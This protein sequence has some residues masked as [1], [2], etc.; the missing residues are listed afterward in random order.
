MC[1]VSGR[2][3]STGSPS[4]TC[5]TSFAARINAA[6]S[7]DVLKSLVEFHVSKMPGALASIAKKL[8]PTHDDAGRT[9]QFQNT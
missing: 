6:Y 7:G 3:R 2:F 1:R 9:F 4:L 5:G 8:S